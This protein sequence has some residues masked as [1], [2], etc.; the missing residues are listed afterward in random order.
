MQDFVRTFLRDNE[1]NFAVIAA[2]ITIL[3]LMFAGMAI[4]VTDNMRTKTN[5]QDALDAAV[6]FAVKVPG[7][8]AAKQMLVKTYQANGGLG[9]LVD[10][11][12]VDTASVRTISA[13]SAYP[14]K[15]AFAG[16]IGYDVTDVRVRA[17]A[18][19]T[20][21]LY[22]VQI[23]PEYAIGTYSKLL[24][25][26]D[27]PKG[28][29]AP[30][31]IASI[32]YLTSGRVSTGTMTMTPNTNNYL[33]VQNS[34]SLYFTME[35][36]PT[37]EYIKPTTKLHLATNDPTTSDRLFVDGKQLPTG[38]TVNI[39]NYVPC[40]KTALFEWEDGGNFVSQDFGFKVTGRCKING[41]SPVMLEY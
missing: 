10:I 27:L 21:S 36:D 26:F 15:N 23:K 33:A 8:T 4:D 2:L 7:E 24:R 14:K 28:S 34:E 16:I 29:S 30:A 3:L 38:V 22:E 12:Y 20:P 9:Y 35:I 5:N 39:A 25:L 40:G 1:G 13:V 32:T 17:K 37:S 41:G 19:A 31:E 6:L 18:K 11:A